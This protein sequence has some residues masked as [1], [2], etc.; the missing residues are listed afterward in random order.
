M[1]K[2]TVNASEVLDGT[3]KENDVLLYLENPNINVISTS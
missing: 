3:L 2:E 1:N